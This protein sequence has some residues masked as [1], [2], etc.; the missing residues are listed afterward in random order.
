MTAAFF[1]G[2]HVNFRLEFRVRRDGAGL[3]E[4]L[5]RSTSSFLVPRSSTPTL[6]PARALSSSLRNISMSVAIVFAVGAHRRFRLP[7]S[8]S[9][10]ALD[11]TGHDGA[12][13]FNVE[14]VFDAHQERLVDSPLGHRNVFV[15]RF[16]ERSN[17][18]S[19]SASP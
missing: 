3:G 11:T 2:Q 1:L 9:D 14:H 5:P 8:S 12:A 13:A 18:F 4:Y 17:R 16:Q 10:A 15:H 7:P 19:A 6:S